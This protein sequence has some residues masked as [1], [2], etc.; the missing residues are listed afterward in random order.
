M[1]HSCVFCKIIRGDLPSSIVYENEQ[2]MAIM[3]IQPINAGHVLVLP[4]TCYE[5]MREVPADLALALF[6][7]VKQVEQSLWEVEGMVC[8]GTNILQ[9]NGRSAWQ[10]VKHVHFHVIPRFAGDNFRIKYQA[11]HPAKSELDTL[12]NAI[13]THLNIIKEK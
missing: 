11:K 5:T 12:A 7:V 6:A 4:K 1:E 10:E 13:K 9:N 8:E 3:D 2:V